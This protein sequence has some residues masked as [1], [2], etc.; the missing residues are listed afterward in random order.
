M[1]SL[2]EVIEGYQQVVED[3]IVSVK[4]A[5]KKLDQ[6]I[7]L[8][9]I[10]NKR[11]NGEDLTENE[12][13]RVLN[14]LCYNDF[15]GCCSPAKKCPWNNAVSDALGVDYKELYEEK[16]ETVRKYLNRVLGKIQMK[17]MG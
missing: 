4:A 6:L 3:K 8:Q 7:E 1:S 15:A 13:Q 12:V 5:K 10:K 2:E 14:L 11:L 17:E 16:R 9:K